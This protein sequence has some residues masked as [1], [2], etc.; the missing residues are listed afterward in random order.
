MLMISLLFQYQQMQNDSTLV[1]GFEPYESHR[2]RG[3]TLE[4]KEVGR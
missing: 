2:S 1:I 4:Y 3:N